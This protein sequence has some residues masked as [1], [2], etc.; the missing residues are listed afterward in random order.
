MFVNIPQLQGIDSDGDLR[1]GTWVYGDFHER[2]GV[3]Q[4]PMGQNALFGNILETNL[5]KP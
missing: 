3:E 2:I 1:E 4:E 5:C